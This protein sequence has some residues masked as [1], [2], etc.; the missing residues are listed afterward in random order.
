MDDHFIT[1]NH[2]DIRFAELK[3][4]LLRWISDGCLALPLAK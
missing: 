4:D 2:L 1:K 3:K